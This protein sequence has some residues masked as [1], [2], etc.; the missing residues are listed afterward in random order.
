MP[1]SLFRVGRPEADGRKAIL[2]PEDG[3]RWSSPGGLGAETPPK[4]FLPSLET[5]NFDDKFQ[6]ASTNL[7]LFL[8]N[9]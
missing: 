2:A 8:N 1:V 4:F 5:M 3:G 7:Q 9:G 6:K